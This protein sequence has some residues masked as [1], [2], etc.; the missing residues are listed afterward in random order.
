MNSQVNYTKNIVYMTNESYLKH[1]YTS[2]FSLK[3]NKRRG[4][5]YDVYLLCIEFEDIKEIANLDSFDFRI[6]PIFIKNNIFR[7]SDNEGVVYYKLL[8]HN[9][10]DV[11]YLFHIDSDTVVID[12]VSDIFDIDITEYYCGAVKDKINGLSYFNA[13]NVYFNL[14]KIRE[15][16]INDTDTMYVFFEKL[17]KYLRLE[18]KCFLW[19][20]DV[21]NVAFKDSVKFI[22]YG[23]NFLVNTY[24]QYR[25]SELCRIYGEH[26]DYTKLKILHYASNPK[27]WNQ[28]NL[29]GE[30]WKMY[31]DNNI[32]KN[33]EQKILRMACRG[34]HK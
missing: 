14:K 11:N 2:M 5:F 28:L 22:H 18:R 12:D 7:C 25:F 19:E 15:S 23:Y 32:D 9:L 24:S 26:I 16:V 3:Y 6:K 8:L 20:Q 27:P 4:V 33:K 13:G 21:L 31:N 1:T 30:I 10:I 17:N 34:F 29:F